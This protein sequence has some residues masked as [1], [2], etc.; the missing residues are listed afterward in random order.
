MLV[1]KKIAIASDHGGFLLKK[2]I[3]KN[4]TLEII[5]F[6]PD[7]SENSVDYP[8]Y[9]KKVSEYIINNSDATCGILICRSGVG[10][11]IAANRYKN[12]RAVLCDS[13]EIAKLS[14]E[15]DNCNIICFGGDFISPKLAI[16]CLNI[17]THTNFEGGRHNKRLEKL[18]CF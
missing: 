16:E 6:G 17:F 1:F 10:M 3:I 15:H 7:N 18:E 12:I 11:S 8:D 13:L 5:D 14:R 9:A 2:E 4:S